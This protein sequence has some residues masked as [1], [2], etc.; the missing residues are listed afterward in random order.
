MKHRRT[1][2]AVRDARAKAEKAERAK[3]D[4]EVVKILG[5]TN[6]PYSQTLGSGEP[7]LRCCRGL[8]FRTLA[9]RVRGIRPML[10]F[11]RAQYGSTFP[12]SEEQVLAYFAARAKGGAAK[13]AFNDA[14]EGL[15]FFE[16]AG[17]LPEAD[18][19]GSRSAVVNAAAEARNFAALNVESGRRGGVKP[20][21]CRSA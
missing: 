9:K 20:H 17:E 11:V 19:L 4:F 14:L 1:E 21:L 16:D 18:R 15:K 8:A 7:D 12:G 13:S 5:S 2:D 6:L 3:W 10:R